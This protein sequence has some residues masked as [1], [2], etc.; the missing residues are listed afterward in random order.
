MTADILLSP[1]MH[2]IFTPPR[3]EVRYRCAYGGRG[4]GKSYTFA[5][6]AAVWGAIEPLRILCTREIQ[7]SIKESFHAELKRVIES[8]PWLRAQYDLGKDYLRGH[9]GTEFLFRGLRHSIQG[10]KSTADIDLCIVEEA[11]DVPE[12]AWNDL[13]PTIRAEKSEIWVIWNPKSPHSPVDFRF[14]KHPPHNGIIREI[15]HWDNPWFTDRLEGQRLRDKEIKSPEEYAH[16]WEGAYQTVS[17]AQILKD[18]FSVEKFTI[19]STFSGPYY[20][21]DYGTTNPTA[22]IE[23]YRKKDHLYVTKELYKPNLEV[24]NL[25]T[26]LL[27]YFPNL[28]NSV[29]YADNARPELTRHLQSNGIPLIESAPKW[30]GSVADGISHLRS[31]KQ[32]II[33]PDCENFL[34]ECQNYQYAVDKYTEEPIPDRIVDANNHLID[35]ARYALTPMIRTTPDYIGV[36]SQ[37]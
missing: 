9:N 33:H 5:Y 19:D 32:I 16:I 8:T 21:L 37:W 6:M 7:A 17:D 13:E 2:E 12:S 18:K 24:G 25:G 36:L 1:K 3:G 34:H 22:L 15:N 31:Y 26:T 23:L 35:A 4:S 30:P 27:A 14:R 11:E 10:I 29:V 28:A 20:G